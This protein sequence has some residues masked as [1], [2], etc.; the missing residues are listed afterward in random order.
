MRSEEFTPEKIRGKIPNL[1]SADLVEDLI[2][3]MI[4]GRSQMNICPY[5]RR[6]CLF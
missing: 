1:F 4:I 5:T 3:H 6:K 2:I